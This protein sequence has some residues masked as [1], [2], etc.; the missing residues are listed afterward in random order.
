MVMMAL[1][2]PGGLLGGYGA[3][4]DGVK[5]RQTRPLVTF[6]ETSSHCR[7]PPS[8][9]IYIR[10]APD[11]RGDRALVGVVGGSRE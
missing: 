5:T 4:P 1:L 7:A 9:Q 8:E 3:D 2:P 6:F 11:Q 10:L